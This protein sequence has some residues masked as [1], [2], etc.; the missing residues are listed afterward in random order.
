MTNMD[1]R[2]S[3]SSCPEQSGR[4]PALKTRCCYPS[5]SALVRNSVGFTRVLSQTEPA[6]LNHG[7]H[8]YPLVGQPQPP[9]LPITSHI[10]ALPCLLRMTRPS[11][12]AFVRAERNPSICI[13]GE[14]ARSCSFSGSTG[15]LWRVRAGQEGEGE[16][17]SL[18]YVS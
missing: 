8:R 17:G 15:G 11:S 12:F 5:P 4:S 10:T 2:D 6:S 3:P 9:S 7:L 16:A 14:A 18:G 13:S 1:V